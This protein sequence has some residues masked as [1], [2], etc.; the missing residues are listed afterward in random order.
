MVGPCALKTA[1]CKWYMIVNQKRYQDGCCDEVLSENL[2]VPTR[3][4]WFGLSNFYIAIWHWMYTPFLRETH[5]ND[6]A[7]LYLFFG[8][9]L[10]LFDVDEQP[11]IPFFRH[12]GHLE[13]VKVQPWVLF[14]YGPCDA[15][16]CWRYCLFIGDLHQPWFSSP[17]YLGGN[18]KLMP[19]ILCGSCPVAYMASPIE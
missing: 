6:S 12:D 19:C 9:C 13:S 7:I 2:R 5:M 10:V 15:G 3:N 8:E 18:N 4:W 16:N 1:L 11:F 17:F 14:Q